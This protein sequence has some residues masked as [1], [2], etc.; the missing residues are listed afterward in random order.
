MA[1]ARNKQHL[2]RAVSTSSCHPIKMTTVVDFL[3]VLQSVWQKQSGRKEGGKEER[4]KKNGRKE[5]R[6]KEAKKGKERKKEGR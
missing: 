3:T 2:L 1:V 4:G 5:R 6:K